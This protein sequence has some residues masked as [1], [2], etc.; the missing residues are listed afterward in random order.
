MNTRIIPSPLFI[1]QAVS[2]FQSRFPEWCSQNAST[3]ESA[4]NTVHLGWVYRTDN[5]H[6]FNVCA[7][8]EMGTMYT[9]DRQVKSCNC[10]WSIQGKLCSHRLKVHLAV[11]ATEMQQQYEQEL[12]EQRRKEQFAQMF[13]DA[14]TGT[15]DMIAGNIV[16]VCNDG[17]TGAN[18]FGLNSE[19]WCGRCNEHMPHTLMLRDSRTAYV[20]SNYETEPADEPDDYISRW[21]ANDKFG[22]PDDYMTAEERQNAEAER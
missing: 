2:E 7:N 8:S 6:R 4:A 11:R 18:I 19:L 21:I 1:Q 12:D 13:E 10:P 17:F 9:V 16:H 22:E 20:A 14:E 5:P 3:L 15:W